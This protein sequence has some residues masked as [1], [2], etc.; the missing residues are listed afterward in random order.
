MRFNV[1]VV[2]PERRVSAYL[3]AGLVQPVVFLLFLNL[4]GNPFL[5]VAVRH[6]GG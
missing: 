2:M 4:R 5:G 6:C 3:I 1:E